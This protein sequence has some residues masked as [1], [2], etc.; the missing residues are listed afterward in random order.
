MAELQR[1]FHS[2]ELS[3][4]EWKKYWLETASFNVLT[5]VWNPEANSNCEKLLITNK[6]LKKEYPTVRP[7][8][9]LIA[10]FK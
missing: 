10:F 9:I 6:P 7:H 5:P 1:H 2:E 3:L 4:D 8:K